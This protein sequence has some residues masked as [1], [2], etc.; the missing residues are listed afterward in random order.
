[1]VV[2]SQ[3]SLN[4]HLQRWWSNSSPGQWFKQ[5][6]IRRRTQLTSLEIKCSQYLA[7]YANLSIPACLAK[8]NSSLT[9]LHDSQLADLSTKHGANVLST[10]KSRRWWNIL[11]A[12]V[13]NPFNVLLSVLAIISIATQEQATF[14]IIM[15][16]VILSIGLRFWQERKNNIA[17]TELVKLVEDN[18]VVIRSGVEVDVPKTELVPGD[19]VRLRGGDVVPADVVLIETVGLYVNQSM[20][21]GENMPVLKGLTDKPV[22]SYSILEADNIC[23][24][25]TMVVGSSAKALVVATGD[26]TAFFPISKLTDS[27]LYWLSIPK[28]RSKT[29]TNRIRKRNLASLLHAHRLHVNHGPHRAHHLWLRFQ[30]LG[31]RGVILYQRRSGNNSRDVAYGH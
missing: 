23:F 8:L 4:S 22:A 21:T 10:A 19:I 20:L 14:V 7:D 18:V 16:M 24:S 6:E 9:G 5:R 13:L 15:I 1:M 3:F 17:V 2:R 12:C 25:G 11:L 27:H 28:S 29:R 30:R 31:L 26:G